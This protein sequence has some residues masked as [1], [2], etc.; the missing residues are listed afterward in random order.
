MNV[1]I[2][3]NMDVEGEEGVT[4]KR[5]EINSFF[6]NEKIDGKFDRVFVSNTLPELSRDRVM[7]FLEKVRNILTDDGAVIVQVPMAEF[8]AKQLFTNKADSMTYYMLYGNEEHP[9]KACYTML[10]VRTLLARAGFNIQQ[11]T[12]AILKLKTVEGIELDL[13]VHSLT[14]VKNKE[15]GE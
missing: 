10:Q 12:E 8:A 2:L 5:Y 3:G 14:A 4:I 7:S 11:A 9:F 1:A 15:M 13:P 6:P